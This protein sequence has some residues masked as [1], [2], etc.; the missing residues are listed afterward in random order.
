MSYLAD[1]RSEDIDRSGFH[2]GYRPEL[3]GLRGISI[4]LVFIHHFYHPLMPGGFFGVDIFFVLSG[5]L[6]TSLLLEEWDRFGSI[7]LKNFYIRRGF[8]LMPAVF[9]LIFLLGIYAI[10][11]LNK[12]AEDKA[13][14]GIWLTLS[15]TSNWFY[16]FGTASA[17]NPLGVT[18]SLAIE[19][20]FYF[21]FPLLLVA[22]L[23]SRVK[24]SAIVLTSIVLIL[25]VAVNRASLALH[26]AP[27]ARLYYASDT[28]AD[29]L[30]LG[31]LTAF[32]LSWNLLPVRRFETSFKAFAVLAFA[33]LFFMVITASSS[34]AILYQGVYVLIELS[35]ALLLIA[36]VALRWKLP[37]MILRSAPLVWLGRVSYGL[38]LWH[39]P[40]RYFVYDKQLLPPS[41]FH[42]AIAI[43]L[44]FLFTACSFYCVERPFLKLKDRF[45]GRRALI[46]SKDAA[47]GD[48][49]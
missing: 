40:I 34:D 15:Y 2:L 49:G 42:L 8:R 47:I 31:C 43:V 17:D 3:D 36:V 35:I 24:R 32:L 12:A 39:W 9:L 25:V 13:F 10:F 22:A 45:A 20:Q 28:R 5:F 33:F 19:E 7:S 23:R 30:L 41:Y 11:V 16:A 26:E 38:Y 18:W 1:R 21:F 44:S 46:G 14:Q 48:A 6:I 4:L 29:A 37:V 27:T